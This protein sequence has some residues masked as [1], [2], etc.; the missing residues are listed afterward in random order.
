MIRAPIDLAIE[1]SPCCSLALR[2]STVTLIS[3]C[4]S[5]ESRER[6]PVVHYE[7]SDRS[8][9]SPSVLHR[10]LRVST[11]TWTSHASLRSDCSSLPLSRAGRVSYDQV[12]PQ[13][14]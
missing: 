14:A 2:R 11:E 6:S 7:D 4:N 8:V 3:G 9:T 1:L 5:T 12:E 10:S 13:G